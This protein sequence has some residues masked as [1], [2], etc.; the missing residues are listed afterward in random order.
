M[1]V[2]RIAVALS[3]QIGDL[4]GI[5]DHRIRRAGI[6]QLRGD[7]V[8]ELLVIYGTRSGVGRAI[9]VKGI[10]ADIIQPDD[11]L[12]GGAQHHPLP[13]QSDAQIARA[14]VAARRA[15]GLDHG[16]GG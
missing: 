6:V 11:A 13:L 9:L 12:G 2:P 15:E 4:K 8:F 7:K 16:T 1:T 14:R 5:E 3:P 10:T